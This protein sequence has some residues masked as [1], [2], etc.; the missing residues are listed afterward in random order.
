MAA[1]Q[2]EAEHKHGSMDISGHEK[3]FAR[4]IRFATWVV[5]V[6]LAL[7]IIAALANA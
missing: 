7:I 6:S 5:G 2:P 1:H 4:F 3:M